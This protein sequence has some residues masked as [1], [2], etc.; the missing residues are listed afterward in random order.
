LDFRYFDFAQHRFSIWDWRTP[1][2]SYALVARDQRSVNQSRWSVTD[3][4]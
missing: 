2:E 4:R 3:S 1:G